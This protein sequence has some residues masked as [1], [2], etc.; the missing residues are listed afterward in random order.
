MLC[1]G[2][3]HSHFWYGTLVHQH[4][5]LQHVKTS[6]PT[7]TVKNGRMS[8]TSKLSMPFA[9]RLV[10]IFSCHLSH[11]PR[12]HLLRLI[13]LTNRQR[14]RSICPLLSSPPSLPPRLRLH[15]AALRSAC[16]DPDLLLHAVLYHNRQF[17]LGVSSRLT[18]STLLGQGGAKKVA[19]AR[20]SLPTRRKG[21]VSIRT[22]GG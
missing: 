9:D 8:T 21:S 3:Q 6:P 19:E 12:L 15:E 14:W 4:A 16:V 13:V 22:Y 18:T 17:C 7:V 1:S 2:I 11:L 20:C 5:S 10:Q